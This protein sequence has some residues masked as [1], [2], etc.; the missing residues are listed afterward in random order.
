MFLIFR[1]YE[2]I[3]KANSELEEPIL[4]FKR[5]QSLALQLVQEMSQQLS[6]NLHPD[7]DQ[8][9]YQPLFNEGSSLRQLDT[10]KQSYDKV[11]SLFKIS[12]N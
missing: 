5:I 3:G 2:L 4:E 6:F 1:I 7:Q 10:N 12:A 11:S 9:E 8:L